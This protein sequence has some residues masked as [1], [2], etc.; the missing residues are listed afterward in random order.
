MIY[1]Y[2][3]VIGFEQSLLDRDHDDYFFQTNVPYDESKDPPRFGKP[4]SKSGPGPDIKNNLI[5]VEF[6]DAPLEVVLNDIV[7]QMKNYDWEIRDDVVNIFPIRGR[8]PKLVEALALKVHDFQA[9]QGIEVFAINGLLLSIPEFKDYLAKNDIHGQSS[10][11]FP[12]FR[13]RPL[14][15]EMRFSNLTLRQLLN[16]IAKAKGGGWNI[17]LFTSI[18]NGQNKEHI[19][20]RI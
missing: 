15:Q 13:R 10:F 17:R 12:W 8:D 1:D 3:I 20:L 11:P 5:T 16:E 6:R 2:D 19:N 18:E 14:P 7:K 4:A 9:A